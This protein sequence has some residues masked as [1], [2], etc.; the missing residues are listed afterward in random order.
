VHTEDGIGM[1]HVMIGGHFMVRDR[2]ILTIDLNRLALE[3]KIARER[4]KALNAQFC[5]HYEKREPVV[6]FFCSAFAGRP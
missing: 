5:D 3:V 2:R 4:R 6:A 1:R